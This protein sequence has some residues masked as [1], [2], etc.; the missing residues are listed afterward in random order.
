M[1]K[2]GHEPM[3]RHACHLLNAQ[4]MWSV[5]IACVRAQQCT[6]NLQPCTYM[7]DMKMK[8][9]NMLWH[10]KLLRVILDKSP[11][12]SWR[13]TYW[14]NW[15]LILNHSSWNFNCREALPECPQS[16]LLSWWNS[17]QFVH[18]SHTAG[19]NETTYISICL[20]QSWY[21]GFLISEIAD[22]LSTPNTSL[23]TSE[24]NISASSCANRTAWQAVSSS[25][26][27]ILRFTTRQWC[28]NLLLCETP[29]DRTIAK[30]EYNP[31]NVLPI[32]QI[33]SQITVTEA[34]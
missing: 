23:L 20:L 17:L 26:S 3:T 22:L 1:R 34:Q 10:T 33:S 27:D 6:A 8:R 16:A 18:Y 14:T 29:A 15:R 28:H 2:P 24:S 11:P 25:C 32:V 7:L 9:V 5:D 4:P 19:S 12:K 21:T 30:E 31:R 13:A